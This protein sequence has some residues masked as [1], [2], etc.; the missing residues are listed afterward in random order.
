MAGAGWGWLELA[1]FDFLRSLWLV[2][3]WLMT[4]VGQ[5]TSEPN[6][7]GWSNRTCDWNVA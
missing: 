5:S 1:G 3:L 7:Y 2:S 6:D 4:G